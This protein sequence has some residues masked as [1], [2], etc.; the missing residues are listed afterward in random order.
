[1]SASS[2]PRRLA[3]ASTVLGAALL[4][5]ACS[6]S[7]TPAGSES[8]VASTPAA[9]SAAPTEAAAPN[10]VEKK[11]AQ[12]ILDES[13]AAAQEET[14]V[15]I[16][17][18]SE[19]ENSFDFDLTASKGQGGYGRISAD[20]STVEVVVTTDSIYIKS[21]A[22]FWEKTYGPDA[23][24]QIGD[25]WVQ[26]ATTTGS[27]SDV[28]SLTDLDQVV[29]GL[30]NPSGEITKGEVGETDGRPAVALVSESGTLWV[31]TTGDPL[32]LAIEQK[33]GG[34]RATFTDWSGTFSLPVP[35]ADQVVAESDLPVPTLP[36][37]ASPT[38][39]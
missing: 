27:F 32:P 22:A 10:G 34:G 20:G 3:A 5:A 36:P 26:Q 13:V 23:A 4:L 17:A 8:S 6:G 19:G 24:A 29:E 33:E 1:M 16:Q 11:T 37:T 31:A 7:S 18:V 39:S 38:A 15:R 30:L 14:S 35:P 28:A 2:R 21:D 12:E 25:K 9:S